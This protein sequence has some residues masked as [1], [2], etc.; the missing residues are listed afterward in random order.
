MIMEYKLGELAEIGRGSSPRPIADQR[1]FDG[2]NIPWI[3]IADATVSGKYIYE[4]KEHVNEFGASYSR[5]LKPGTLIIAASGTLGFPKFLGCDGCIHDGWMYF[6]DIKEDIIDRDYLYYY[7]IT[8]REYFNNLSYGA[9]IQNI[10]TPIVKATKIQIP[11]LTAQKK[12][13]SLLS[14]YDDLIENNLARISLLEKM[15]SELYK[16]WFVRFRFPGHETAKFVNGLPEGW[17]LR[18]ISEV[19]AVVGGGTPSTSNDDYWDGG[20]PWL[21]PADLADNKNIYVER[22]ERDIS[23][24]G[25]EKSST[26]LLPPET[27]LLSSR[28][29]IGYVALAKNEICTNQGFKSVICDTAKILPIYLYLYFKKNKQLLENYASGS[30]FAELSAKRVNNIKI[31]VPSIDIQ[32]KFENLLRPIIDETYYLEK[33]NQNLTK[34]RDLLLPRLMSGKLSVEPLLTKTA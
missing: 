1:Y 25:L 4:T 5:K 19:G 2:G 33:R 22:G 16:E 7:L 3:K 29:P 26:I 30:T 9:A 20:I 10:N 18:K 28:A 23:V 31:P 12:I 24:K 11:S 13:A 6:S 8:L 32:K 14:Y 34:Q 17:N 27:V 15:A 21:T